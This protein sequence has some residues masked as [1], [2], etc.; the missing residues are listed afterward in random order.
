[1]L[2]RNLDWVGHD[3]NSLLREESHRCNG[4]LDTQSWYYNDM[5]YFKLHKK[6][7]SRHV[8][9]MKVQT[10]DAELVYIKT[11]E[12]DIFHEQRRYKKNHTPSE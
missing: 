4:D 1:M 12:I 9:L 2:R 10:N 11:L 6:G 5:E 7:H 8:L 3:K